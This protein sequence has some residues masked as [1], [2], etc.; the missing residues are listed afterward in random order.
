MILKSMSWKRPTSEI[1]PPGF[2]VNH[3]RSFVG[4]GF[5][6]GRVV[7]AFEYVGMDPNHG[8][9]HEPEEAYIGDLTARL[10]GEP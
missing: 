10:L 9:K 5:D 1:L 3:S 2:W 4:M 8:E 6:L 7:S